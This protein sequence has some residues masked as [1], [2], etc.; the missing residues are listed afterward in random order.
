MLIVNVDPA[1]SFRQG[2]V[3][4]TTSSIMLKAI[5]PPEA[6]FLYMGIPYPRDPLHIVARA[7][8]ILR[9]DV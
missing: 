5:E 6:E 2:A 9:A 4:S 3:L 7:K 1:Y 8:R